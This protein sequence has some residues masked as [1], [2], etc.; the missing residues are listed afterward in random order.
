[1]KFIAVTLFIIL[2]IL[3]DAFQQ[4]LN[5]ISCNTSKINGDTVIDVIYGKRV[6][7]IFRNLEYTNNSLNNLWINTEHLYCD[8]IVHSITGYK[9]IKNE[10]NKM[11]QDEGIWAGFPR[12]GSNRTFYPYL[13]LNENRIMKMEY[14]DNCLNIPHEIFNVSN[15]NEKDSCKY[16]FNYYEPSFD[17]KYLAIGISPNGS[18]NADILIIDVDQNKILS[19]RIKHALAGNVQWLPNS[20]GFFYIQDKELLNEYDSMTHYE[21]SKVKLHILNTNPINDRMIIS[22][23]QNLNLRLKKSDWKEIFTFPSSKYVL[24]NILTNLYSTIY[25]TSL[26]E[27]IK[28]PSKYV[29]WKI[30]FNEDQKITSNVIYKDRFFAMSFKN[31]P[32]G[33]IISMKLSDNKS[34]ILF[35]TSDYSLDDM[36]IT[37]NCLYVSYIKNGMSKLFKINPNNLI[38]TEVELPFSGGLYLKPSFSIVS[39][40]QSSNYLLFSLSGYNQQWGYYKC[41]SNNLV[42]RTDVL[43]VCNYLDTPINIIDEEIEVTSENGVNVPLSITYKK[44]IKLDGS[45]PTILM[46]YGA[47]GISLKP[48]FNQNRLIWYKK[49]GI[50]AVAHVRGGGEKGD[51]WYKGGYKSTKSNSW[52]DLIQCTEYLIKKNYTSAKKMALY[53]VS[54][55]GITI[56]RAITERPDLYKAA[57]ICSGVLNPIRMESSSNPDTSEFG[58]VTDSIGFRNLFDM[59]TYQHIKDTVLYPSMLLSAGLNDPRVPFWQ[60]GKVAA[61]IQQQGKGDNIVLIRVDNSGHFD[62]PPDEDIYSFLFWQ[63]GDSDF[64]LKPD[65]CFYKSLKK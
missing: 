63:L 65:E 2:F 22:R 51:S 29:E 6:I 58:S 9:T 21:D 44:G 53:G 11:W 56:G 25:F 52:K 37:E 55:G 20:S 5:N 38:K 26:E 36:V 48:E 59:D 45:N 33:Q 12:G 1:M 43:P 61:R 31:N 16:D 8:T 14:I 39:S 62:Y 49:G 10:I 34:S 13:N 64:K 15:F 18:E 30:L 3:S 50:Y 32:N 7:D 17:G 27:L 28:Q 19:E 23:E 47:F 42:T 57:I 4:N 35:D 24:L 46:A 41:D 60:S 54:A 40:S